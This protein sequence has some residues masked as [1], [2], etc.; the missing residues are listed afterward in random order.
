ML[1]RLRRSLIP[2]TKS[3][4]LIISAIIILAILFPIV[5][6][7]V[8]IRDQEANTPQ[9]PEEHYEAGLKY[10]DDEEYSY[11]YYSRFAHFQARF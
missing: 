11:A 6:T 10:L 9:T 5:Q 3:L 7:V 1:S 4:W 2:K 8:L